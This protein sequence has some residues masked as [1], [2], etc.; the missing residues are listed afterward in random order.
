MRRDSRRKISG[1]INTDYRRNQFG[2]WDFEGGLSLDFKPFSSLTVSLGPDWN[3]THATA[4]WVEVIDDATAAQGQRHDFSGLEQR[5]LVMTARINWIL[6]PKMS[7]QVYAQPLISVGDY[8]GFKEF[9]RPRA[10]GSGATARTW[11]PSPDR[12]VAT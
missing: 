11:G 12:L 6:S 9:G 2:G 5:E 10:F 1:R 7:V 4:Q 3:R 8:D